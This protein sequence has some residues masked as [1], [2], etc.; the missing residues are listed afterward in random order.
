MHKTTVIDGH[1]H[2]C[3][4]YLTGVQTEKKLASAKVDM[5]L[6]TPE[7][8]GSKITYGLKN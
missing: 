3:G 4:K 1:A 2:A 8:Y 6:L 7:Q 5:V